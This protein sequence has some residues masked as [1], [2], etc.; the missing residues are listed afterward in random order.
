[1]NDTKGNVENQKKFYKNDKGSICLR[2][3]KMDDDCFGTAK[4]TDKPLSK[5]S[6]FSRVVKC[7][8]FKDLSKAQDS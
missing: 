8:S 3:V 4:V 7:G 6:R 1:M 2:C 5:D